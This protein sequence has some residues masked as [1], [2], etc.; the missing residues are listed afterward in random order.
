MRHKIDNTQEETDR[1]AE[2]KTETAD[3]KGVTLETVTDWVQD[4]LQ[5]T[6]LDNA[7]KI[8]LGKI[9][10][11]LIAFFDKINFNRRKNK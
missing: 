9:F 5:E 11:K 8:A 2:I 3:M 4:R 10:K 1:L 6:T 7:S